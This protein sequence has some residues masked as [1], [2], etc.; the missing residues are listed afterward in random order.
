MSLRNGAHSGT[1]NIAILGAGRIAHHMADTLRRMNRDERYSSLIEPYAVATRNDQDRAEAFAREYG[2]RKA[3]GS[4]EA[5]LA[6]PEVDLVYIAT[7]HALHADHAI[8]CMMAGKNVLV[9]K[10][11]TANVE[12]AQRVIDVSRQTHMLCAE[13]I[14]TRYMPSRKAITDIIESGRLGEIGHVYANLSYPVS[15]KPRMTD[16]EMA[17]GALLDLGVYP[18]NFVMMAFP[19]ASPV[20]TVTSCS[21][22]DRGVDEQMAATMWLDNGVMATLDASMIAV[23]SRQGIIQGSEGYMVVQNINNPERILIYDNEH[24][25]VDTINVPTQLTGYEYQVI[26]SAKALLD[27]KIECAAMPHD[28]TLRIMGIMDNM[29]AA[30]GEVYPFEHSAE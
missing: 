10:S 17:G 18:I 12:Q 16:P 9:E 13:A 28:E 4:Y 24:R 26:D 14:W 11:F 23:G 5:L 15:D 2:I 21:F 22:T 25:L 3:Y 30:W 1:V 27:G 7:P 8:A 19:G 20:R 29:R 6:D